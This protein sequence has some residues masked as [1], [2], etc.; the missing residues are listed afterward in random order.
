[1]ISN[2]ADLMTLSEAAEAEGRRIL[3]TDDETESP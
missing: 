3:G 2:W 1:M